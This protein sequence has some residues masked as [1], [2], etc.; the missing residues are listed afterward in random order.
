MPKPR[1]TCTI[2]GCDRPHMARGLCQMHYGRWQ[3]TGNTDKYQYDRPTCTIDGCDKP[4]K[5][6]KMC[7]RHYQQWQAHGEVQPD[8]TPVE[9]FW[10]RVDRQPG[11][12]WL[13][14]GGTSNGYGYAKWEGATRRVHRIAY[15]I[16]LGSIPDDREIDHRCHTSDCRLGAKCPHRRC[17]NPSHLKPVTHRENMAPDRSSLAAVA[18]DFNR[19]KTHC[20]QEHEYTPE[21]TYVTPKGTRYCRACNRAAAA[22]K[23]LQERGEPARRGTRGL[24]DEQIAEIRSRYAAGGIRQVDLAAEYGLIQSQISAIVRGK[25]KR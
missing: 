23:N 14:T 2:D 21:N 8:P 5:S 10:A 12:C 7:G 22:R 9:A 24:T 17:V 13:W 3:R 20:P 1:G 11:G 19:A 18:G 6:R 15:E 25:I 4:S 16:A